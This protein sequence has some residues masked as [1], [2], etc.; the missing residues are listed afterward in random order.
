LALAL[1]L[2]G[3]VL[4]DRVWATG[5]SW[6]GTSG[7]AA[8]A[9]N[10][11][12]TGVPQPLD[13]AIFSSA[14]AGTVAWPVSVDSL[15]RL[16]V[17]A[18]A[19]AFQIATRLGLASVFT[20]G[21]GQLTIQSGR[22]VSPRWL[23][24][25]GASTHSYL[26]LD[27]PGTEADATQ[28]LGTSTFNGSGVYVC[29]LTAT[30]GAAF[31]S[32]GAMLFG[33]SGL[34]YGEFHG[35]SGGYLSTL[36]TTTSG[37]SEQ[38]RITA[39]DNGASE[40]RF[41][42]GAQLS[43]ASDFFMGRHAAGS[44]ILRFLASG[45][46]ATGTI[47]GQTYVG[48]NDEAGTPGGHGYLQMS[49]GH[50]TMAGTCWL[51][52]P[53][54]PPN[55]TNGAKSAIEMYGGYL[56][57]QNGLV[58]SASLTGAALLDGGIVHVTGGPLTIRQVIPFH[59]GSASG[60]EPARLWV[61]NQT[62]GDL[63][64]A[65]TSMDALEVGRGTFAEMHVA[66]AG[67][68]LNVHGKA[69]LF[70]QPGG[71]GVFHVDSAAVVNFAGSIV[72]SDQTG[73][74][75]VNGPGST[76][77][78]TG[79]VTLGGSS[80]SGGGS[81]I[82]D[83]SASAVLSGGVVLDGPAYPGLLAY[84]GAA[85]SVHG[86]TLATNG[87]LRVA[88]FGGHASLDVTDHLDMSGNSVAYVDSGGVMTY[89][90]GNRSLAIGTETGQS[91]AAADFAIFQGGRVV[92]SSEVDVRGTLLF[93]VGSGDALIAGA[94]ASERLTPPTRPGARP[95]QVEN[96]TPLS[97][98][99][100]PGYVQ[101]PLT[102]V[103]GAGLVRGLG[104]I[105]G[106]FHIDSPTGEMFVAPYYYPNP[107]GRAVVGD[108]TASDG[109][110][111]V[112]L[113]DVGPDTLVVL[114]SNGGDLGRISLEGG[115]LQLPKPGHLNAGDLLSGTGLVEGGLDVRSGGRLQLL[116]TIKGAVT[117]AGEMGSGLSAGLL[118]IFGAVQVISTGRLT[119]KIGGTTQDVVAVSGAATLGGKLDVR[120]IGGN[121]PVPGDTLTL[122]TAGTV[123]GTFASVTFNGGP[124]ASVIQVIYS[125]TSVRIA[126]VGAI[127]A[128]RDEPGSPRT[129][130][131][132][133]AGDPRAA[134]LLLDLPAAAHAEIALY[135]VTGRR[136]AEIENAALGPGRHHYAIGR[137]D[138]PASG[139]YFARAVIRADAN[140]AV[141]HARVVVLR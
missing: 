5:Y 22:M 64:P 62:T 54:D 91:P 131:F 57:L 123:T 97:Q 124:S 20:L 68:V 66:R 32:S 47:Y 130:R 27:G 10:W 53:D 138:V 78:V 61:E 69:V 135:D 73:A 56:V 133:Q 3:L 23:C 126:I 19:P 40:V 4:P 118:S 110:V 70:D 104:T 48:A 111:S 141:L 88:G 109:F 28:A 83:S 60:T 8:T 94:T 86:L 45:S 106:R 137:G 84:R 100:P 6:I 81:V 26:I 34:G 12:P 43:C 49:D 127:T 65:D 132:A 39:G 38:G 14:T 125:P 80:G 59:V 105:A 72:M 102:R 117:L 92:A 30:N 74:I 36:A 99:G 129:L 112:G 101:S 13:Y 31:R 67:T 90:G 121:L 35:N 116:G 96:G 122:L 95:W 115:V 108:S 75:S 79:P 2:A 41:Y 24:N 58:A 119:M 18:G 25:S 33:A 76:L 9:S 50:L 16:Y 21:P 93:G 140:P 42:D 77:N 98:Y 139:L 82:A 107:A 71:A 46:T 103:L 29:Q 55:Q 128:V 120:A 136:L 37:P 52:D 87:Y 85:V 1:I 51:G 17:S 7:S 113:V 11:S 63:F 134:E 44:G 15:D 114:D 89:S